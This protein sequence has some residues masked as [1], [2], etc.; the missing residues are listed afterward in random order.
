MHCKPMQIPRRPKIYPPVNP[1][2]GAA[3]AVLKPGP[4]L[5]SQL[6]GFGVWGLGFSRM[7]LQ[8]EAPL[9][10]CTVVFRL[11]LGFQASMFRLRG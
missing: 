1:E 10:K 3:A 8:V 5:L 11:L 2:C 7:N 9:L 4:I 6:V